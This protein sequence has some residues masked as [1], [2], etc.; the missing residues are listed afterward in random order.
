MLPT[1]CKAG[2]KKRLDNIPNIPAKE[3][4]HHQ[5]PQR[6][7]RGQ[8]KGRQENLQR[9]ERNNKG[10]SENTHLD[11]RQGVHRQITQRS[12]ICNEP[13][14]PGT[15]MHVHRQTLRIDKI[16]GFFV[17]DWQF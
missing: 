9:R 3:L 16:P 8:P 17:R 6:W 15:S 2:L 12:R 5:N 7:V 1:K 13:N 4:L 11:L 10:Y 14:T